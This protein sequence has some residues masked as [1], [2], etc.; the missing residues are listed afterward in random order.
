MVLLAAF[1]ALLHR[2]NGHSKQ[3][4]GTP[5]A[6]RRQVETEG[7]IGLFLNTL[8]L[9]IDFGGESASLP[10]SG[11]TFEALLEQVREGTL[12][13]YAHQ[14]LP[15]GKLVEE[16]QPQRNLG[17]T[18]LFQVMLI[19]Q[20][21]PLEALQLPGLRLLP[22]PVEE[23]VA[24]FDL[25]IVG[26]PLLQGRLG[27]S[28]KYRR[29]L[30]DA[31]T[32]Q[33]LL[34]Q[35]ELMLGAAV[36]EPR[37]HIAELPLLGRAERHQM[38]FEWNDVAKSLDAVALTVP[39]LFAAQVERM[40]DAVA[41]VF[42]DEQ[43]TFRQLG[44]QVEDLAGRLRAMGVGSDIQTVGICLERSPQM[45][46][47]VLGVMVS[48]GAYVPLDPSYPAS[49][50]AYMAEDAGAGIL[51]TKSH[52][53]DLLP[54]DVV[55]GL[56]TL[57]LDGDLQGVF[58]PP[59]E[60][61]AP[62]PLAPPLPD[63]L[64]YVIY[65][66][67][68]TGRPKGVDIDHRSLV[69][70]LIGM[71]RAPGLDAGDVLVAVTSLSF[72]ITGLDFY[73]PLLRGGRLVLAGS[74]DTTDGRRLA[75]LLREQSATHLQATPATWRMLIDS[76]WTGQA[77]LKALCGGEALPPDLGSE[78]VQR[79]AQ[80]WNLYGP[81]ET[82]V[83]ATVWLVQDGASVL[84]GTPV[85]NSPA[86]VLDRHSRPV[87]VGVPGELCLGGIG[88]S[89]GYRGRPSLTASVFVPSPD[90]GEVTNRLG[91]ERL[92]RTGDLARYRPDGQL[93]C[94]GR[95][96]HQV[97]IRGFRIELGEIESVLGAHPIVKRSTVVPWQGD[98][99]GQSPATQLVAWI[100]PADA[101]STNT[102]QA[103]PAAAVCPAEQATA[104]RVLRAH[105]REKL[106][107]YMVPAAF[108]LL[109]EF[110][111]TPNR[112]VDR[113][114]LAVRPLPMADL[115]RRADTPSG[116]HEELLAQIW[117]D[118]LGRDQIGTADNFFELGGHSLLATQVV[119]RVR[120]DLGGRAAGAS[121]LR[122]TD[123]R[124]AGR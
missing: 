124:R 21:A 6:G 87:P 1:G 13:A 25:T 113:K 40:P 114:A 116:P 17:F 15:F 122:V 2:L 51:L 88:V 111:L 99:Q 46:L 110:P 106:P 44:S 59:K 81:T 22:F 56:P 79:T 115:E 120:R 93:E 105:L 98:S 20:N 34:R 118:V 86:Y 23:T 43:L 97:K 89:P 121:A 16:L 90:F 60:A 119:A 49:R 45:V 112:K 101:V 39:E 71:V 50:L 33:R 58:E 32:A 29:Q 18:P 102:A 78:L 8:A 30:F 108:V 66:S 64:A 19:V 96:D 63:Q 62:V 84:I 83:W 72:D 69:N 92:Y 42:G 61:V 35:F 52:L 38:L 11:P 55:S 48:G 85:D 65:T 123:R 10:A 31:T 3:V 100:L 4:I 117:K 77:G 47:A 67:G 54:E 7:L 109:N 75:A 80:L 74:E 91:G 70:F 5:I 26:Q 41:L 76:G 36:A 73:L 107:E 82:T 68:S 24:E 14:D 27:L 103:D 95:L 104:E 12:G 53:L 28:L 94:L 37:L 9:P 57:C